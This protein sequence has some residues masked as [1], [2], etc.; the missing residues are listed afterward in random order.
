[1]NIL[2]QAREFIQHT[3]GIGIDGT[4]S[5]EA[6]AFLVAGLAERGLWRSDPPDEGEIM[7]FR[8]TGNNSH[9]IEDCF[10]LGYL[11]DD[12]KI[13]DPTYG[14]GVFWKR[15]RPPQLVGTDIDPTK[16]PGGHW[17]GSY[18][19]GGQSMDFTRMNIWV[20]PEFDAVVFDPDYKMQG[21]DSG[22]G[23][24]AMNPRFGMAR[25]YRAVAEQMGIIGLGLIECV[26]VTKPGGVIAVKHMDQ[27]VSGEVRW[28]TDAV[29]AT[30]WQLDCEKF[31]AFHLE[32]HRKQ[33]THDK[34]RP[35][36][37]LGWRQ[38][39]STPPTA[40]QLIP[41][42]PACGG[43]GKVPRRQVHERRNY[44][45]LALYRKAKS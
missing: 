6:T 4:R 8:T 22:N 32:G 21:T 39:L 9:L 34:C 23:P 26:R 36:E 19:P 3:I 18:F 13:L 12:M 14:M 15:H 41:D 29:L 20:E 44:S 17:G 2:E 37:G 10:T 35:C 38:D 27:V 30:M 40:D 25:E 43:Q 5:E 11:T 33:P 42:C 45:T 7:A 24:A 31:A 1:M 28:Q 16:S